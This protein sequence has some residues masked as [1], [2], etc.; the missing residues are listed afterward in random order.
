MFLHYYPMDNQ[1]C[2]IDLASC[3]FQVKAFKDLKPTA[4]LCESE[5]ADLTY[6]DAL[7]KSLRRFFAENSPL[8]TKRIWPC[9]KFF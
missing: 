8:I 4:C 1:V 9:I 2:F 3:K 6:A 5:A 7:E